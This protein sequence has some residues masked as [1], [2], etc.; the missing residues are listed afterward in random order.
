[1][2]K[3]LNKQFTLTVNYNPENSLNISYCDEKNIM[4]VQ[5]FQLKSK[6]TEKSLVKLIKKVQKELEEK[7]NEQQ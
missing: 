2:M 3:K 7:E 6:L 4:I 5:T 1:M